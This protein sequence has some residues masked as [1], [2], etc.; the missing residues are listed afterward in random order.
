MRR[1]EVRVY[2]IFE[3]PMVTINTLS[4]TD[5]VFPSVGF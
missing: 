3:S 5:S 4:V 1:W 2:G